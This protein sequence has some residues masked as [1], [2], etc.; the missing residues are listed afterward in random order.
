MKK[1]RSKLLQIMTHHVALPVVLPFRTK[2]PFQYSL[3]D[4]LEFEQGTLGKDLAEKLQSNGYQLLPHYERH[5]CKHIIL[6]FEMDEKGEACMQFYF[7]GNRHY[8]F[9]VLITV[10]ACLFLM[11]DYW[12][13]FYKNFKKGKKGKSFD[14]MDFNS[15]VLKK[16]ID[17]KKE[18]N[19]DY[20]N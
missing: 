12:S 10:T 16:T 19:P 4:L 6:E 8:S 18:F 14:G 2:K 3:S 7:L 11:P 1:L 5:D 17:L 13:S 9:P 15:V 20:I